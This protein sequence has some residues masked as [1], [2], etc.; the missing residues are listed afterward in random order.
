MP[1]DL[2]SMTYLNYIAG[3][4][5]HRFLTLKVKDMCKSLNCRKEKKD[6]LLSFAFFMSGSFDNLACLERMYYFFSIRN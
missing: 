4:I 6:Y 2:N 3:Y 1:T 5:Q